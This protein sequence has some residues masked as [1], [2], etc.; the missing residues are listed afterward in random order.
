MKRTRTRGRILHLLLALLVALSGLSLAAQA[1]A[2]SG[3]DGNSGTYVKD[4]R[5]RPNP[6]AAND[7][8]EV[9]GTALTTVAGQDYEWCRT[10]TLPRN[11]DGS[12]DAITTPFPLKFFG[13]DYSAFYV[14]NNGNISFNGSLS[15]YTP[16]DL[17][18]ATGQPIIAP[19]FADV[20]TRSAGSR[21]VTYGASPDGKAFCVNWVDV[22]YYNTRSDKL[23]SFQLILR[24]AT[25]P[26]R[27][28]GDFDMVFNYD[29]IL[30]ETG[31]A[32]DGTGGL[33]GT[34]AAVGFSAGTGVEGSFI[35]F[36]GSF[37]NGALLDGG[38]NALISGSQASNVLGRYIFEVRNAGIATGFGSLNGSVQKANGD[39][40]ANAY[41][42]VCTTTG[43]NCSYTETNISGAFN[44][45]ARA[46]GAQQ[47]RVWPPTDDL[48]AGGG[49][50]TVNAGQST[51]MPPI[52]LEAPQGMPSNVVLDGQTG[53]GTVP[54]VYYG[55]PL[56]LTVTGCP[57]VA[58]PTYTV[59][60]EGQVIRGPLPL[61]ENPAGTYKATIEPLF[62][63]SGSAEIRTN[64]PATCGGAQTEFNLYI[65][66]SGTVTDQ[67]G[68]PIAGATVTLLR[69]DAFDGEFAAVPS[70]SHFMSP[71]NRTNPDITNADGYFRWDVT[72]GW[73]KVKADA[74]GCDSVTTG[75]MQVPPERID[76]VVK[77]NCPAAAAPTALTAPTVSGTAKV[78]GTITAGSASWP[79]P[80]QE[81]SLVLMRDGVSLASA[82]HTL[83]AA[84]VGKVFT[85]V[86][87]ARRPDYID[88]SQDLTV[89][90]AEVSSSSA[91]VTGAKTTATTTMKAAKAKVA[92]TEMVKLIVKIKAAVGG[93]AAGQV[94]VKAGQNV[95]ATKKVAA[96]VS[97]KVVIKIS[98]TKL[99]MG[100]NELQALF[101]GN[102]STL[103]SKSKK[104]TVQVVRG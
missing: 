81:A 8:T 71:S 78:G 41:V 26:G 52:V 104:I 63:N 44:F 19:F 88:T 90:F 101:S 34:S 54:S 93:S 32:S 5:D 23:N 89:T 18:G 82:T 76:L 87:T 9:V 48:F 11:D 46:V 94:K 39:P 97:R 50:A 42:Q 69:S 21:E 6:A 80:V 70:G 27:T 43:W 66:P 37:V 47:V 25:Q 16:S 13:T 61:T 73:Y 51:T 92:R 7:P 14:N 38:P 84:D 35:Q 17:T 99:K 40:V 58:S 62:P 85:A 72:A 98:A 36:P 30:W 57:N 79:A 12:T 10:N 56:Q 75:A 3:Q 65:D 2:A 74:T 102:G 28:A 83:T 60:L 1:S 33:G 55:D 96:G 22:G 20:D 64:V 45:A 100:K 29:R 77:A 59:V 31:D 49:T 67:W 95:V 24:S 103:G 86:S 4:G 91:G 68:R 53:N 15:Q